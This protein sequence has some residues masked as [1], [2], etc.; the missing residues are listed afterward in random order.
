VKGQPEYLGGVHELLAQLWQADLRTAR[1]I[2]SGALAALHDYAG[3]SDEEMAT[4]LRGMH[5][6]A[7]A[8]GGELARHVDFSACRSVIDIGGCSGGLVAALCEAH[9][10]LG[11]TLFELPRAAALA[12]EILRATLGGDRVSIEAGDILEGP[13]P[14]IYDAAV[15]RALVQ[16]LAPA[17]AARAIAYA[18]AAARGGSIRIMEARSSRCTGPWRQLEG[19][20]V[21]IELLRPAP[22][23]RRVLIQHF[24]ILIECPQVNSGTLSDLCLRPIFYTW[25]QVEGLKPA[26][27]RHL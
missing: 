17:D 6:S 7:V 11:A 5:G 10:A 2:L 20:L 15:L 21:I 4:M 22:S 24:Q 12:V 9:P 27:I 3:A 25:R 8:A 13:L 1:S 19:A 23:A 14:A 26:E 18:A 16:V